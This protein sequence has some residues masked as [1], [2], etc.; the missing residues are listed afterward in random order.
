MGAMEPLAAGRDTPEP[1]TPTSTPTTSPHS[2]APDA[3]EPSPLLSERLMRHL[4]ELYGPDWTLRLEPDPGPEREPCQRCLGREWLRTDVPV[5][6]PGFG[7]VVPCPD[8]KAP[9]LAQRQIERIF[10]AAEIPAEFVGRNFA[11]YRALAGGDQ[12]A[13]AGMELWAR[14]GTGSVYLWGKVGR[15]KTGLA[16]AAVRDRIERQH[17]DALFRPTPELLGRIKDS[18]S[19]SEHAPT[20][21][22]VVESVQHVSLLA[23]D[24]IGVDRP[25]DWVQET[26][27]RILN[28]RWLDGRATIF[29]SNYDLLGLGRQLGAR[30]ASRIKEMCE[31]NIIQVECANLRA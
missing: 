14:E 1:T 8:C 21:Q 11:T 19:K 24:D 30:T 12:T 31:P 20:E 26:L 10:G 6:H 17:V 3:S 29:T 23:L 5:S 22:E 9:V 2:D 15:G 4:R 7:Q 13:C 18:Y 16:L 28:R 25:T 27:Y